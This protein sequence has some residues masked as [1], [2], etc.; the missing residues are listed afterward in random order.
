MATT[1]AELADLERSATQVGKAKSFSVDG[2][3]TNRDIGELIALES[4]CP[5]TSKHSGSDCRRNSE[6]LN[7][8]YRTPNDT[9]AQPEYSPV[10]R[11]MTCPQH[12]ENAAMWQFVDSLS[13]AE[14]NNPAVR[15]IVRNRARYETANNSYA[16]GMMDT[17]SYDT[18][19]G[20][21]Q[22]QLGDTDKA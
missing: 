5:E 19:A 17:L 18:V 9:L 16:D 10:V 14:A 22:L 2:C 4:M 12:P 21:V 1:D 15:K 11:L 7:G 3:R 6:A 8:R 13:A 20:A